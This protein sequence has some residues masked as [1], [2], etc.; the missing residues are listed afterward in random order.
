LVPTYYREGS[1]SRA[2][3]RLVAIS[4]QIE[5]FGKHSFAEP[6]KLSGYDEGALRRFAGKVIKSGAEL[7]VMD[8]T[9]WVIRQR[10]DGDPDEE[11]FV[12][13]P[14]LTA[15]GSFAPVQSDSDYILHITDPH[16][17]TGPSRN[18][19]VWRLESEDATRL[20][21]IE[22]IASALERHDIKKI[23]FVVVTGDLT[24]LGDEAEF[25]EA[26]RALFRLLGIL[27]LH[28]DQLIVVPGNHDIVWTNDS[29]YTDSAEVTEA[30]ARARQNYQAFY[31]NLYGHEASK[32]LSMARRYALPSGVVVEVCALN[33]SSL[34]QGKHFLAGMGRV[35]EGAFADA[36]STLRWKPEPTHALRILALHHHLALTE[37]LEPAAGYPK[38][39]GLAVDAPRVLRKAARLGVQLALHGH[40]HRSFLWRSNIYELP[41]FT[42][43][44]YNLGVVSIVGGGSAGSSDTEAES[45]FFNLLRVKTDAL[46][47]Q[48]FRSQHTGEFEPVQT[49]SA[50]FS[51]EKGGLRLGEWT[52]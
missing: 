45:N 21:L 20:S 13:A 52:N 35:E 51:I 50:T 29:T 38:G 19:H 31:R 37:D 39:F 18:Q 3:M 6:P 22:A 36:A 28:R 34:E 11:V 32:H 33:S 4:D 41:E 16:F 14:G 15:S 7:R 47:L 27:G 42:H 5:F 26:R 23:A 43:P 44:A 46:E 40:K 1:F 9:I 17:A 8:T 48:I 30:P 49:Y 24:F 12:L 2:W 25:I 10:R